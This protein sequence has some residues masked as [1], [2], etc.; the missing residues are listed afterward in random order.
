[1]T[2]LIVHSNSLK[3]FFLE[4]DVLDFALD[5]IVSQY[6]EDGRL[7]PIVYR[8][9]KF[10]AAEINYEIHDN[11]L[12]AIIDAFE[13]WHHFLEGAQHTTTIYTNYKNLK[14]FMSARV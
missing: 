9:Y 3:P 6:E 2:T 14:Y 11:E 10:F 1:V 12:L 5:S 7:R 13:E 8:S 4:T